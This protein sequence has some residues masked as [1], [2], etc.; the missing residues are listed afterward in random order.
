MEKEFLAADRVQAVNRRDGCTVPSA[1]NPNQKP[2]GII[3]RR[4]VLTVLGMPLFFALFMFLPAGTWTWGNG[5]LFILVLLV[6]GV[7]SIV[8]LWRV[9]TELVVARSNPASGH[10]SPGKTLLGPFLLV[11]LAI[12]PVA[13]LDDERFHWLPCRGGPTLSAT[14]V[15]LAVACLQAGGSVT[16]EGRSTDKFQTAR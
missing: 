14:V 12:F 15:G 9:N 2:E 10:E 11:F 3:R 16:I 6:S 1:D 5:W 13:A 7:V 4:L 8:S